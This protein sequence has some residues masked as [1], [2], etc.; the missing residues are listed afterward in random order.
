MS[1]VCTYD[2][3]SIVPRNAAEAG[4]YINLLLRR[5]IFVIARR[6]RNALRFTGD[7]V[8]LV[9]PEQEPQFN[10][11]DDDHDHLQQETTRL[12]KLLDHEIIEIVGG[13]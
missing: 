3:D 9:S 11:K 2:G 1:I 5:L 4:S 8:G 13:P 7:A 12:M 6:N 10:D